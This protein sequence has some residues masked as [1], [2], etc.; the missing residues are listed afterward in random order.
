MAQ[1]YPLII[2]RRNEKISK[3]RVTLDNL[4]DDELYE[5][6]RF[7]RPA[8]VQ[9]C[10]LLENDLC[11]S[12]AR[13]SA[14]P[15]DTQ[16]LAALQFYATGSFQWMVGRSSGLSQSS[17]CLAIDSV[18]KSLVSKSFDGIRFPLDNATVVANKRAFHAVA[19]FPNVVAVQSI[20]RIS[21]SRLLQS[22]KR[23]T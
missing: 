6:T 11:H 7:T 22:T 3:P 19:G 16:I 21:P 14:I 13:S 23:R 15:V 20:A 2:R 1:L 9:L 4:R 17:V 5:M 12:T 18:T 8:V 10:H